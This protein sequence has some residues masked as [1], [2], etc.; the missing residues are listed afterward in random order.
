MADLLEANVAARAA[1][2]SA[3]EADDDYEAD[4]PEGLGFYTN[5]GEED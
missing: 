5:D 2:Q 4:G 3:L 1:E